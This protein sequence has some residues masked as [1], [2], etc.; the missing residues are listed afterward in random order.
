MRG[1]DYFVKLQQRMIRRRRLLFVLNH[2]FWS[3]RFQKRPRAY[4]EEI[5][6]LF[7]H[8]EAANSNIEQAK[9]ESPEPGVYCISGLGFTAH[10]A[11]GTIDASEPVPGFITAT[12]GKTKYSASCAQEPEVTVETWE[13]VA[14]KNSRGGIEA[15]TANMAFYVAIN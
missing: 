2:P 6:G 11:V 14:V 12:L 4:V 10:N 5:L 8:I 13:P 1:D 9:V 7:D 3:Y 15:A